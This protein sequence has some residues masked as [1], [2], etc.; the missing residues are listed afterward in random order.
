MEWGLHSRRVDGWGFLYGH[1]STLIFVKTKIVNIF[2]QL[3]Y[4]ESA[5][6]SKLLNIW[7]FLLL[8]VT[9][10]TSRELCTHFVFSWW[11]HQIAIFSASLAICAGNSPGTP[12]RPLW[13]HRNV[14]LYAVVLR[15]WSV[16][17]FSQGYF[18]SAEKKHTF[19]TL[20]VNE[21]WR[22]WIFSSYLV[23]Q[24]HI[25]F[26]FSN[27]TVPPV[28]LIYSCNIKHIQAYVLF[29]QWNA[30]GNWKLSSRE[31]NFPL[32]SDT[33]TNFNR[34]LQGFPYPFGYHTICS[35]PMINPEFHRIIWV[36][37]MKKTLGKTSTM[38]DQTVCLFQRL[39]Y[40]VPWAENDIHPNSFN[41]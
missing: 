10:S 23:L 8:S 11:R 14:I 40:E 7:R 17:D 2:T 13:C 16:T 33:T 35:M 34:N 36:N 30:A 37:Q 4:V 29:R 21:S 19:L 22:I 38:Q 1:I 28:C 25:S 41:L 20:A 26:R 18:I 6:A 3:F 12:S 32:Y 27:R 5:R 24:F 9:Y 39:Y 31:L 15:A